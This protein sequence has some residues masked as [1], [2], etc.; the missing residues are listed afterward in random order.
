MKEKVEIKLQPSQLS[1]I[2]L[3]FSSIF[4]SGIPINLGVSLITESIQDK[5][6]R[7]VFSRIEQNLS[8]NDKLSDSLEKCNCFPSYMI[9][10]IRIGETTGNLNETCSSLAEYYNNEKEIRSE[11]SSA[12]RYPF[13]LIIMVTAI[14]TVLVT[15]I[16]PVFSDVLKDLG[17]DSEQG[18]TFA[19][20]IGASLGKY[21]LIVILCLLLLFAVAFILS[22]FRKTRTQ[23]FKIAVKIKF[24]NAILT[25]IDTARFTSV[26]SM[27]I[28]SGYDTTKAISIIP[29]VL[30]SSMITDRINKC[31]NSLDAGETISKSL[32]ESGIFKG[33]D[34]A[35]I[36]IAVKTGGLDAC[37]KKISS[38][39][40][41]KAKKSI[42][43]AVSYIEP[44]MI[45]VL[46]VIIGIVL[47][48]DMLPLLGIISSI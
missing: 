16:S 13:I 12:V 44:L 19:V 33:L 7:A 40:S 39:Y 22:R 9:N 32:S 37:L 2:C 18:N 48:S 11:I 15:K 10:M 25:D 43:S 5:K 47:V 4:N 31:K 20:S 36:N 27:M 14:L 29:S 24:I 30:S 8:D 26:F 23:L 28:S 42:N 35:M 17:A 3:Q 41:E 6:L 1:S 34:I 46:S 38:E 21:A 45:T